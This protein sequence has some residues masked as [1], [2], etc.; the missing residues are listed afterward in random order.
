VCGTTSTTFWGSVP[1]CRSKPA[2]SRIHCMHWSAAKSSAIMDLTAQSDSINHSDRQAG[3]EIEVTD[4]M[5]E[6]GVDVL[7][8][9]FGGSAVDHFWSAPD[10]AR[11]VYR[12]MR[13][14]AKDR[15]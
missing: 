15:G 14:S 1:M 13:G 10:L 12:A 3:A 7:L 5:I 11:R 2:T 6:A 8:C 9:E 4:A